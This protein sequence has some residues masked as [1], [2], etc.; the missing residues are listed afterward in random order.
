MLFS[1]TNEWKSPIGIISQ[2]AIKNAKRSNEIHDDVIIWKHFQRYWPF[3]RGIHR[4]PAN[5]PHK[6]QWRGAL[7]FSL[8][9]A[10]INGWVNNRET[11]DLGRYRTHYDVTVIIAPGVNNIFNVKSKQFEFAWWVGDE[12]IRYY[13]KG[14]GDHKYTNTQYHINDI[15]LLV[16][17]YVIC[18]SLLR[19]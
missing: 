10:R 18:F 5:S 16:F 14:I 19:V 3:V 12:I 15:Y 13:S 4:Y 8:I 2:Q 17:D 1:S 11:G 7:M 6:D 9:W